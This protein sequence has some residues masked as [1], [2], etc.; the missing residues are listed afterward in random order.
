MSALGPVEA[1]K[2]DCLAR[3]MLSKKTDESIRRWLKKLPEQYQVDM[4]QRLNTERE[5]QKRRRYGDRH[6]TR[7]N[8]PGKNIHQQRTGR[9]YR[10]NPQG[11]NPCA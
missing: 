4:R 6:N 7:T 3:W 11:Y 8:G 9:H 10:Y 1:H 2:R 5:K